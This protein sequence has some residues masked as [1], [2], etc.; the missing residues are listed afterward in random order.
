MHRFVEILS[1]TR[2]HTASL[3]VSVVVIAA[4]LSSYSIT[5]VALFA[6]FALLF[7]M[8]GFSI[9]NIMDYR[10]DLT[11]PYK[12]HFPSI[13]GSINM[14]HAMVASMIGTVLSYIYGAWLVG[15][16][17]L[18]VIFLSVALIAGIVYNFINK[19]SAFGPF[20]I[21]LSF[22]SLIP[23]VMLSLHGTQNIIVF[24]AAFAFLTLYYQ[25]GVSGYLKDIEVDQYNFMSRLGMKLIA[26]KITFTDDNRNYAFGLRVA[27]LT[28]G[29]VVAGLIGFNLITAT[30]FVAIQLV[31][32]GRSIHML[33]NN[34]WIRTNYLKQ[35][36]MIEIL[37]YFSLAILF[38]PMYGMWWM[39][40][41]VVF[42]ILWFMA[43]N[44]MFFGTLSAPRV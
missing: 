13:S 29:L 2:I 27:I 14:G 17:I 1:F 23:Y 12:R 15:F 36:S 7:H 21:S 37:N 25:I 18:P 32:I 19:V 9:N 30:V 5:Y 42:P 3:T 8:F 35:M 10:Y 4:L 6:V 28:V 43:F 31:V 20:L 34:A 11:D 38:A 40:F 24:Y 39:A 44:K 33:K 26:G 41:L 16:A 22:A